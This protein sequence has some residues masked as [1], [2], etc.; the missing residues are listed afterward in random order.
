MQKVAALATFAVLSVLAEPAT[1][2]D[3]T[4]IMEGLPPHLEARVASQSDALLLSQVALP[5]EYFVSALKIWDTSQPIKVCFFGG[6][7]ALRARIANVASA[8][9]NQGGHVP[10][11]F[12]NVNN[13]KS[14]SPSEFFHI[15]IG[16]AY[17]GYWSLVGTDSA[18]L[19]TQNEQSMNFA[20]F[21]IIP[22]PDP[23]F[24]RVVLHE[25][26]HALG[27]QHEH[28]SYQAPCASEFA[29]D[30][31]Y[32]H[33]QGPP[34]YWSS[35]RIDHNLR[36]RDPSEGTAGPIFDRDSIML[37]RFPKEF[38]K[39]GVDAECYTAD[40][41]V[42]SEEDANAI[43]SFYPVDFAA[44]NAA[45]EQRLQTFVNAIEATDAGTV[46]KSI[47]KLAASSIANANDASQVVAEQSP[48][49][50]NGLILQ[51]LGI[52]EPMARW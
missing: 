21:D 40:N 1:A 6:A 17:K 23:E 15:R 25:F 42:I 31:I 7:P 26:G 39:A 32:R 28:Q 18:G 44:G 34:N 11:D 52:R 19:A 4:F 14:C 49:L 29:W 9:S 8:W 47:A 38:Y 46:E 10:L 27:F 12:G 24:S 36:P 45:R 16:F 22:P 50:L 41:D 48:F 43:R 5:E 33:L 51:N 13:P 35:E 2:Q 20:L 30:A 37:Y 3:Q